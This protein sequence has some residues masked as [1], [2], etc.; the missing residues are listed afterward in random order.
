MTPFYDVKIECQSILNS[1]PYKNPAGFVEGVDFSTMTGGFPY[2]LKNGK[3]FTINLN[4]ISPDV[5]DV[6][7]CNADTKQLIHLVQ[8]GLAFTL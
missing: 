3:Y 5:L 7:S 2:S 4:S 8:F 1:T 6:T